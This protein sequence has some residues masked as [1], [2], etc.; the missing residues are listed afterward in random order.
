MTNPIRK[1]S[2]NKLLAALKDIWR[3][4]S[5]ELAEEPQG[6]CAPEYMPYIEVM[7]PVTGVV[8]PITFRRERAH[9]NNS[10]KRLR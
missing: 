6:G 8:T 5:G 2:C 1:F 9:K 7:L 4:A 10:P 3:Q